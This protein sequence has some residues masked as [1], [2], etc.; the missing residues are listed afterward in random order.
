MSDDP[1][2]GRLRVRLFAYF[3]Q[4]LRDRPDVGIKI[5]AI[6]AVH[7]S[8][9]A[10]GEVDMRVGQAGQHRAAFEV[11]HLRTFI[12]QP[13]YIAGRPHRA[14]FTAID[15]DRFGLAVLGVRREDGRIGQDQIGT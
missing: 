12:G 8:R 4:N 1:G 5:T 6:E 3:L 13:V 14:D 11:D 7:H 2:A 10:I 15:R 9:P